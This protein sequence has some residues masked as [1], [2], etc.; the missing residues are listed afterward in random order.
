MP[1]ATSS[2][3][4]APE[5]RAIEA[6]LPR[7][8]ILRQARVYLFAHGYVGF[9]MDDL[10]TELGMSKK[11]LYV[12]FAGKDEIIAAIIEDIG[13]EIRADAD[14]LLHNRQLNFAEKLRGFV[15]GMGERLA[16]VNPRML[17]DLQRYAPAVSDRLTEVREKNIPYVFG[18]FVEEGQIGGLVRDDL[19]PGF[20]IEFY[21]QAMQGLLQP[22]TLE[23]LQLAPREVVRH[24]VD[25]FFG[26]LLTPAGRKQYEKLF[27]R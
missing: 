22:A 8:R 17:R 20:A 24:A 13:R 6:P 21:L 2:L 11:T 14:A 15:E 4:A 25:L 9:R 19:P 5:D 7:A 26:G 3:T 1:P 27:P 18:R 23:R 16:R 12:H 10:A